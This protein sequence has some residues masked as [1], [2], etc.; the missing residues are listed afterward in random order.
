MTFNFLSP[1]S[2][3]VL[4]HNE[5]LSPKAIG[6]KLKI[7]S[8]EEG[9]PDLD[10]VKIAIIGVLENRNDVNYVGTDVHLDSIRKVYYNLFPGNWHTNIAHLGDILKGDSV[11]DT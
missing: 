2:E 8:A 7:H 3:A 4:A 5:L 11:E 10:N 1:V 6:K 9:L